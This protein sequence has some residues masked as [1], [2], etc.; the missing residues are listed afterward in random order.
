MK[1]AGKRPG[2]IKAA[3]F[4]MS[5]GSIAAIKSGW[6]GLVIDQQEWLQGYL[7]ILQICLTKV[8]GFSGC[9]STR[10]LVFSTRATWISLR[11]LAEKQVR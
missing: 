10:A 6:L 11:P 8:Y 7:P 3:G 4:D 1:A 5:Q 9:T 2:Q